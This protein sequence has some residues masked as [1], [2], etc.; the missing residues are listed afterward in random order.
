[1]SSTEVVPAGSAV[2]D[3]APSPATTIGY[4]DI[5]P[6]TLYTAQRTTTAVDTQLVKY[7][8]LFIAQGKDDPEP[9]VLWESGSSDQGVLIIPL[10]MYKTW[11]YSDGE[12]LRSWPYANGQPPAEA[13]AL[14]ESTGK[15]VFRTYN[16]IVFVPD[17]DQEM[18]VNLRL[19][20]RSARP[21][22]NAINL[23]VS[24][25][26]GRWLD[27]AFRVTTRKQESGANKWAVPVVVKA[28]ATAAQKKQ[29]EVLLN[30]I[31]PGLR[32]RE[33]ESSSVPA[34]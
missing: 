20:S 26:G 1:M 3:L 11:T 28:K 19:N 14:A 23:E 10:H 27:S 17:Y 12:N 30:L 8:D 15:P 7:G 16:Y 29:A 5:A 18:P 6:P 34:I 21:A 4:E 13:V 33:Q 31:L 25:S 24:R 9:Q 32:A 2:P 22:A